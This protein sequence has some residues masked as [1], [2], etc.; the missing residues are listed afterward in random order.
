MTLHADLGPQLETTVEELVR[1]GRF[2][3]KD[4][5]LREGVRLVERRERQLKELDEILAR[6][7]AELDAGLGIP[8]EEVFDELEKH[9]A[10]L[11]R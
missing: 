9:W 11:A 10:N 3:T 1:S 4:D 5:V 7:S 6:S 8:A 2:S